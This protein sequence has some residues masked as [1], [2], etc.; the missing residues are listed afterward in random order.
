[1]NTDLTHFAVP[2]ASWKVTEANLPKIGTLVKYRTAQYQLL[3][4]VNLAGQWMAT[5][6]AE[7]LMPVKAWQEISAPGSN[8]PERLS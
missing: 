2:D 5:D 1:M 3:G 6:G 4:Y 8:W 7:E